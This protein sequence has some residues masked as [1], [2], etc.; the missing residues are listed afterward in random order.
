M[1]IYILSLKIHDD[2]TKFSKTNVK[3]EV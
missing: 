3:L 1:Y 2:K